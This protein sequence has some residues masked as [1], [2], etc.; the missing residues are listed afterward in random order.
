MN[1]THSIIP[2]ALPRD[3][4]IT[5][6]RLIIIIFVHVDLKI[7]AATPYVTFGHLVRW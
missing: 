7:C 6:K 3:N 2:S 4:V 5:Q 1:H